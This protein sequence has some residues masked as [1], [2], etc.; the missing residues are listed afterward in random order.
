MPQAEA[1]LHSFNRLNDICRNCGATRTQYENGESPVCLG[2]PL[3]S[4]E[5]A[6][7]NREREEALNM[8]ATRFCA[9]CQW[10]FRGRVAASALASLHESDWLCVRP[11]PSG[12]L[13]LVTGETRRVQTLCQLQRYDNDPDSCGR[14]GR[15]WEARPNIAVTNQDFGAVDNT[16][17]YV[18]GNSRS[19]DSLRMSDIV[20]AHIGIEATGPT[21]RRYRIR[22]G[23]GLTR[24]D[25]EPFTDSEA[26]DL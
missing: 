22:F 5:T 7:A 16:G 18:S 2:V 8:A 10:S 25:G 26:E 23:R 11:Y 20:N 17:D 9:D 6:T 13:S 3:T 19:A 1:R 12:E 24:P 21:E 15:F 14:H 4:A